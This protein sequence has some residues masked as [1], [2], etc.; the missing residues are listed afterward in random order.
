MKCVRCKE[1]VPPGAKQCPMCGTP[2]DKGT[3]K[4]IRELRR[5]ERRGDISEEELDELTRLEEGSAVEVGAPSE[6]KK[7]PEEVPEKVP[8]EVP[9]KAPEKVPEKAPEKAPEEEAEKAPEKGPDEAPTGTEGPK[10]PEC[11]E[12]ID[13]DF[14]KCP[15]CNA[16]LEHLRDAR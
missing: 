6:E 10:C 7:V 2:I 4:R 14:I 13:L 5:K 15:S 11:G 8:E 3:R 16:S 1:E 9:E 12:G